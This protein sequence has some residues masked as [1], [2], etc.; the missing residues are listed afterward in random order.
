MAR[1]HSLWGLLNSKLFGLSGKSRNDR[2]RGRG[3]TAGWRR[4]ARLALEGLEQRWTPSTTIIGEFDGVVGD[5][6][7]I[8]DSTSVSIRTASDNVTRSYR[9]APWTSMSQVDLDGQAGLELVFTTTNILGGVPQ[10][11]EASVVTARTRTSHIFESGSPNLI[12][13]V[14]LDG[15]AGSEI[16][17]TNIHQVGGVQQAVQAGI[18]T[19]RT[20]Q[21]RTFEVGK[22]NQLDLRELDGAAGQ[23]L[24][25]TNLNVVAGTPQLA[26]AVV[27]TGRTQQARSYELGR[28][29][30]FQ[31]REL[32]GSPGEEVIFT[33]MNVVAGVGQPAKA[34]ILTARS[35]Q[36]RTYDL[37]EPNDMR[38][39]EL[40]GAAGEEVLFTNLLVSGGVGTR[41]Q[42]SILSARY[43]SI[44][45]FDVQS[46]NAM[47]LAEL[48]GVAGDEVLFT[49][50]NVVGGV[51]QQAQATVLS[52]RSLQARTYDVGRPRAFQLAELDG[53]AGNEV[54][55]NDLNL[56]GGAPELAVAT[57]LNARTRTVR[58]FDVGRP[59]SFQLLD[60]DGTAGTEVLFSDMNALGGFVDPVRVSI[61][62]GRTNQ[63]NNYDVGRPN[64]MQIADL[65]GNAGP[66][67]LFSNLNSI[68]GVPQQAKATIVTA[69]S[70][71]IRTFDVGRPNAFELA[72][73]DGNAG[74]EVL[75][76]NV[77]VGGGQGEQTQAT[78]L[79]A[80][81]RQATTFEVG[82]VNDFRVAELDGGAGSEVLFTNMQSIA[83]VPQRARAAVLVY[84]RQQV[85]NYDLG[86]PNNLTLDEL[87]GSAG[88]EVVLTNLRTVGGVQQTAQVGILTARTRTI[89]N[90]EL[91]Q[92]N[93][94]Q[95]AELDGTAGNEI[96]FTNLNVSGG[97]GQPAKATLVNA[98][99]RQSRTFDVG[100]PNALQLVELDGSAGLEALFTNVNVAA[101]VAQ[102]AQATILT[103][104][105]LQANTYS[106]GKPNTFQVTELD[107]VAGPELLFT[108]LNQVA[109]TWQPAQATIVTSRTRLART[110]DVG[111]PN[112]F[113]IVELDGI[114]GPEIVFSNISV[115]AGVGQPALATV[116]NAR[117]QLTFTYNVGSPTSLVIAELDGADGNELAFVGSNQ[118]VIVTQR[119]R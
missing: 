60:L 65:D 80:R 99:L 27:L 76:T 61:L 30:S 101:G 119:T 67:L 28:P 24:L 14:D 90:Y 26:S 112:T 113:T 35:Q 104:R 3:Y 78:V 73:L 107:G 108:N 96:L 117:T 18:Y 44:H 109:G 64:D 89:D 7:A 63:L 17:F 21:M 52:G 86:Q 20:R 9:I 71:S 105:S 36:L 34:S 1:L 54:L 72:E 23:E 32:D 102:P 49:N 2:R 92:P 40:D 46:P 50:V 47:Q 45:D 53:V 55:F 6:V 57:L 62:T 5:D 93:A 74:S 42:A 114:A 8:I 98:R 95:F 37:D 31:F 13:F 118:I 19:A 83:G 81:N 103:G 79:S 106:V 12:Q 38:F 88:S 51:A 87:D 84:R 82:R 111:S 39:V 85:D 4:P 58:S 91:G 97:V 25:F 59:R 66:E 16:L 22:P 43:Q 56:V 94:F 41:A 110:Y 68:A 33:N 100:T 10:K 77:V 15:A 29:N 75:F 48:D 11:A 115:V 70:Q 116:L 69:R